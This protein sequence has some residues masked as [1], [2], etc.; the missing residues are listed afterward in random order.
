MFLNIATWIT[1]AICLTGTVLNCKKMIACFYLWA[2][3]NVLWLAFDLYNGLYSRA[4]LDIVQLMLALY[5][6]YEWKKR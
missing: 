2:I 3:G 4:A 1:T 5:G 6:I